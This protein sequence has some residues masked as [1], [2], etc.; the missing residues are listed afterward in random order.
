MQAAEHIEYRPNEKRVAEIEKEIAAVS[1]Q[2]LHGKKS[3]QLGFTLGG[4]GLEHPMDRRYFCARDA[5]GEIIAFNVFIPFAGMNG[6]MADITRRTSDAAGGVT[7]KINYDAFMAFKEE[8]VEW[9]SLGLAPLANIY[10]EGKS[11][12]INLKFLNFIY[13]KCNRFYG[14]KSLHQAKEKYTPTMWVPGYF[15]YSTKNLTP[16]IAYAIVKIQNPGG[17]K[18]YLRSLFGKSM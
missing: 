8:G 7:E 16:Q 5:A 4:V 18:D 6:Y 13:E 3:G 14:F 17:M 2:W 12:D 10:E 1:A 9:G 15:V 11:P